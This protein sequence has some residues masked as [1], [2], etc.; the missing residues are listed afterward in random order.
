MG[1]AAIAV[2]P[3]RWP[4]PFGLTALEAMAHGAALICS[5]RGGLPEVAGEGALYADPDTPGAVAAAVLAL[6]T[7]ADRR[8]ALV[9][10]ARTRALLFDTAIAAGRLR[11]LRCAVLAPDLGARPGAPI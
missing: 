9:A 3:S 6:A 4:E 10:V 2:V 8:A 1:R 5:R 7:D 11:A